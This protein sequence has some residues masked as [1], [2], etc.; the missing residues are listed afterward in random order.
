MDHDVGVGQGVTLALGACRKQERAHRSCHTHA[1][2][3]NVALDILHGVIDR[4]T[5][6]HGAAG[7]IDIQADILV[8][9]LTL[10][11]QK[12]S[13]DQTGSRRVD[14]FVEHDDSIVEQTG[15]DVIGTFSAVGLFYYIRY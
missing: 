13:N 12:L 15:E 11:V 14:L 3:G 10:E 6:G 7:R 4:H 1:D 9:I 2:G 5:V 8:G